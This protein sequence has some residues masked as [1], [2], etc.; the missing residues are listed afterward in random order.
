MS[1]QKITELFQWKKKLSRTLYIFVEQGV[2]FL[3]ENI[4]IENTRH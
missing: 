3:V 2:F 4:E 1:Q